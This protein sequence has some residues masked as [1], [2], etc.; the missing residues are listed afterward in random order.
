MSIYA[1]QYSFA[2]YLTAIDRALHG[3]YRPLLAL[4]AAW[5]SRPPLARSE[6]VTR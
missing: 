3:H 4:T 2:D 6:G 5:T 1:I